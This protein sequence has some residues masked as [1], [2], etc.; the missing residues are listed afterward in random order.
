[1]PGYYKT[2]GVVLRSMRLRE[3]DRIVHLYTGTHGRIGAVVKGVRR[4]KSRFGGRLEPFFRVRL[5]L[6]EGRGDLHTVTQAEAIEWYP[7]LREHG[8]ALARARPA[9]R[10]CGCSAK[11]RPTRPPTTCSATSC[12][13]STPGR[14]PRA[15]EPARLPPEAAA[16]GRLRARAVGMRALWR[17]SP[18]ARRRPLLGAPRAGSSAPDCGAGRR[19]LAGRGGALVHGDGA[20]GARS[21]MLPRRPPDACPGRPGGHRN[22]RI[23]RPRAAQQR[24]IGSRRT[25]WPK[26]VYDFSEGSREMRDLLGGKGANVAEMTRI[27]GPVRVPPGFTITTEACVAYMR[28]PTC[29]RAARGAGRRGARA[30]R[31][32][33]GQAARRPGGPAARLSALR[34]ARV[35]AGDDGHRPEP[36]PERPIG[37]GPDREHARRALRLGLLPA[38]RPDVRQRRARASTARCSRTRSPRKRARRCARHRPRHRRPAGADG[39]ASSAS[40]RRIPATSSRRSHASSCTRRSGLCSTPGTETARSTT[41]A[42]TASPTTGERP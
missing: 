2:E 34:G 39:D 30:P 15:G 41:A 23:P 16:G 27:G 40:S 13:C 18:G 14:R 12:S 35:D 36:R 25:R 20:L 29:S 24:G 28:A 33:G 11:A 6:Y 3:A 21:R 5:V 4:T 31:G 26:W 38:V 22:A 37:R 1:M 42:Y 10:C 32:A 7:R 19:L 8:A 9:S 17:A